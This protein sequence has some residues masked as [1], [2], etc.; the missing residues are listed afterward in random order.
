MH[1]SIRAKQTLTAKDAEKKK[2][3]LADKNPEQQVKDEQLS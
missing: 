3:I 2:A 1:K